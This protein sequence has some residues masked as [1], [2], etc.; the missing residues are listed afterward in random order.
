MEHSGA[1]HIRSTT[2]ARNRRGLQASAGTRIRVVFLLRAS[3]S[4]VFFWFGMLK[5]MGVSPV[6][7]LL[8]NSLPF[9]AEAPFIQLL[10]AAEVIIAIG[11]SLDRFSNAAALLMILHLVGTLT[12]VL[13]SPHMIFSPSFPVL[14]MEGEFLAKNIVLITAGLVVLDARFRKSNERTFTTV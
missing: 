8:K 12:I 6:G 9:V 14:T 11:L 10:G 5:L 13:V 4:V 7:D 3:L 2:P 1:F